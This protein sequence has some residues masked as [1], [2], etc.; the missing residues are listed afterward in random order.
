[1]NRRRNAEQVRSP[2][3]ES[4]ETTFTVNEVRTGKVTPGKGR[5]LWRR[6]VRSRHIYLMLLPVILF[7]IIYCYVPM[8]GIVIAWKEWRPKYGIWGS[9]WVGWENFETL[10]SQKLLPRAVKNT[11]IISLL[12]L[13]I[14]FPLPILFALL[15]NEIAGRKFKKTIQT[16]MYL[17]N[18][19]S[20]VILGGIVKIL[21]AMDDGL[22]NN[23]V[24]ACGGERVSFLTDPNAFYFILI[25]SEIWKGTGWG[26][27]IYTASIAGIDPTLYE[28]AKID[29]CSR[30]GIIFRIT[31]PMI[32]PVCT[33]MF[34]MQLSNIMNAGFDS[35]YNLYNKNVYDTADI[36]D[37]YIYRLFTE[38]NGGNGYALSAAV[39]FFKS[40]INFVFLIAGNIITKKINGYSMF[41]ID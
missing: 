6:I 7:Y 18:F 41:T 14:C 2:A 9:P 36:L 17:P 13:V 28:A 4:V 19:I 1:M 35:V 27:I 40:A 15:I 25:L 34:I 22:I 26:T 23:I 32:M 29:G 21:L 10:F 37:T 12:K 20:W 38:S 3:P 24:A 5:D 16:F 31:F 8:Y 11:I 30:G 39:G 33:V